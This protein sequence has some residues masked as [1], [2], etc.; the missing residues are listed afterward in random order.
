MK[1]KK[2]EKVRIKHDVMVKKIQERFNFQFRRLVPLII[3][4]ETRPIGRSSRVQTIGRNGDVGEVVSRRGGAVYAGII[5][6]L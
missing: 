2:G 1:K 4:V 6:G 5:I 3:F